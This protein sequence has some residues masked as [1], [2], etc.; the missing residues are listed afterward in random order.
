MCTETGELCVAFGPINK[1]PAR[2]AEQQ[3][4]SR[5]Q[6]RPKHHQKIENKR[7]RQPTRQPTSGEPPSSERR[8]SP[9]TARHSMHITAAQHGTKPSVVHRNSCA[10]QPPSGEPPSIE[11]RQTHLLL[12]PISKGA[13]KAKTARMQEQRKQGS[14]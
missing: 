3:D 10:K 6:N 5:R 14:T 8:Q 1:P 9:G 12:S 13:T 2:P 7:Q 4:P 11:R